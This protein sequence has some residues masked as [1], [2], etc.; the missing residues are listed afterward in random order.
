MKNDDQSVERNHNSN[1]IC[2]PDPPIESS[3]LVVHDQAKLMCY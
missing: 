3:L 1:W 2:I